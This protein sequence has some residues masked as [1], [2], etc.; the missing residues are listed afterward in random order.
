MTARRVSGSC[1]SLN[2]DLEAELLEAAHRV[3]DD[4]LPVALV[5]VVAAELAVGLALA[6]DVVADDEDGVRDGHGR[7]FLAAPRREAVVLR[8]EV[9]AR[10]GG[11]VRH[12]HERPAQPGVAVAGRAAAALARALAHSRTDLRPGGEMSVGGETRHVHTRLREE[13][14]R[15]PPRAAGDGVKRQVLP[16]GDGCGH[17]AFPHR[18]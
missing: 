6:Q 2:A 18:R 3:A 4:G 17:D 14:L 12:L 7:A 15:A 8:P 5:E 13:A 11:G 1:G 10:A 16:R 9:A